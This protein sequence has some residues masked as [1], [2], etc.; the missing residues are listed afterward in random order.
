MNIVKKVKEI[1]D[2]IISWRRDLHRIP[3]IG[4]ELPKTTAYVKGVLEQ[5]GI[6]YEEFLGGNALVGLIRGQQEGP[7]LALRADMDG[8]PM[9]EETGLDFAS[10][11]ENMHACGHDG[12]TAMLLG[13]AQ[14]LNENKDKLKGNVKLFFQPAEEGPGG[15]LPMIE[16]GVMDNPQVDAVLGLHNGKLHDDLP[17]G[18]IGVKHGALMASSDILAI[19]IKGKG[20]HGAYPEEAVD[21]IV[22]AGQVI[23]ALQT[24]V[25]RESAAVDPVVVT[26]GKIQGGHSFN[27]IPEEV[28]MQGTVRT[29]SNET[30]KKTAKRIKEL[31]E[32]VARAMGTQAEVDYEFKYPPLINSDEFTDFF[33]D[34]AK[35]VLE[36]ESIIQ[37]RNPVM[38][39]EDMSY[40]LEKVPG[41]YFFLSNPGAIDGVYHPHHNSKF[42]LDES[43]FYLGTSLLVQASLDYLG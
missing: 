20:G 18:T 2:K 27:I 6:E 11:N 39:A 12:H 31:V 24:I 22:V 13:A 3:E 23:T 16:A 4:M 14:I 33:I 1:E 17:P 21:P 40:F 34:S 8:L 28:L 9:P 10:E 25:S 19:K 26:I 35:E 37:L 7:T 15:A 38:G 41:T 30:R 36:E 43:Y 42:D 5:L 29:F 32:G